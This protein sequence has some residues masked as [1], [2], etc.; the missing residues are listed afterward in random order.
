MKKCVSHCKG[1]K[2]SR[3]LKHKKCS[4]INGKTRKF[5]RLSSKYRMHYNTRKKRCR[6]HHTIHHTTPKHKYYSKTSY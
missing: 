2:L 4:I 1:R 3:C 5:C 6:L